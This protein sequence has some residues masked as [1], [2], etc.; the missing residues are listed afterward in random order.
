MVINQISLLKEI[1]EVVILPEAVMIELQASKS[2][3]VSNFLASDWVKIEKLKDRTIFNQ[4]RQDLDPGE[5]EAI[6]LAQELNS[7]LLI[8]EKKGRKIA[9]DMGLKITGIVGILIT[10]KDLGLIPQIKPLLD[11]LQQKAG[12]YLSNPLRNHALMLAGE[13][14]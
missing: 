2:F 8:D 11:D 9:Q 7:G 12:F 3:N 1:F 6:A 13:K 5:A 14:P 10:A 4:L